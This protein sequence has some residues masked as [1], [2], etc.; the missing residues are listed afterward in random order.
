MTR[1]WRRLLRAFWRHAH[2]FASAGTAVWTIR[3]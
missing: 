1:G 3:K 2:L